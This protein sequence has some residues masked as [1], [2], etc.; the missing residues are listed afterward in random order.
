MSENP[1]AFDSVRSLA[2]PDGVEPW[3]LP[4]A[5]E[6]RFGKDLPRELELVATAPRLCDLIE[7][8]IGPMP[9]T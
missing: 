6:D 2:C 5:T 3:E 8:A 4:F 9:D 7:L 1:A